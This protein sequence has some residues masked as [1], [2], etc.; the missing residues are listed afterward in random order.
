MEIVNGV[1]V[2]QNYQNICYAIAERPKSASENSQPI[3]NRVELSD[4]VLVMTSAHSC[5]TS[6]FIESS[7]TFNRLLFSA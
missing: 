2:F 3:K 6:E 5:Q 1:S 4:C 7:A